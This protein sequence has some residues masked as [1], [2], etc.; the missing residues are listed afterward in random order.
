MKILVVFTGGT[1]GSAVKDGYISTD[2]NKT[3][4]L[5]QTYYDMGGRQV[6]FTLSEPYF[7]LSENMTG[8]HLA[9]LGR[10]IL[11]QLDQ[12][13]DGIIVTHGTDTI[14]YTAA[15]LG[16]TLPDPDIPVMLVSSNY[17]LDD[18]RAKG[19]ANF[20]AAVEF[21]AARAGKGVFVPYQNDNGIVYIHRGTRL[22]PHLP[23]SDEL[24]SVLNSYYGI[25][26]KDGA[27]E[28]NEDYTVS[29]PS[30]PALALPGTWNSDI[31]R[32]YPYPG[33]DYPALS[34]MPRAVLLDTYHSGTV[35]SS[36]PEMEQFF[37]TLRQNNVPVFLTG[38][39]K[40]AS[41]DSVKILEKPGITVLPQASPI[42]MYMKLWMA[43]SSDALLKS[44]SLA[45]TM[46][47]TVGEDIV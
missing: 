28:K 2:R 40:G 4:R 1:I 39:C 15:A 20:H 24:T 12:S 8:S 13:Y 41:Y 34:R 3:H 30:G 33:M 14:Q 19:P 38:A 21:I 6:D 37:D 26:T 7:M 11:G 45:Q 18:P 29:A 5:I 22:L 10:F 43:C 9:Q 25:M 35:C 27:F 23:Y 36:T 42:A 17:V 47:E 44:K 32:I 16:Y 46:T 31:V